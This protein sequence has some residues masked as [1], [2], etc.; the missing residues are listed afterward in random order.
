MAADTTAARGYARK[1][2]A[3][4]LPSDLTY[5]ALFH[6]EDVVVPAAADLAAVAGIDEWSREL[7]VVAAW[8]H[9]VGYIVRYSDNE[10]I[11]VEMVREVLPRMGFDADDVAAIEGMIWAT[12]LPQRPQSLVEELL[13]D[14]DLDALGRP[15]F[16]EIQESLR[17]ER[18]VREHPVDEEA[19]IDEQI[20]FV[21]SH[22]YFTDAAR[23]RNDEAKA[24]HLAQLLDRRAGRE[25]PR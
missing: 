8:F 7:L 24:R 15:D 20:V 2:L 17:V 9:D 23:Q 5:H 25:P 18:A 4:E 1:R 6:T 21:G 12:K 19:W 16:W 14:A 10:S 11:A 22:R 3:E 13:A